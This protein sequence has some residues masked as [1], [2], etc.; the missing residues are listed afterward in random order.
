MVVFVLAMTL[1]V[2]YV[3]RRQLTTSFREDSMPS[4]IRNKLLLWSSLG[5][6]DA[7]AGLVMNCTSHRPLALT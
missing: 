3:S 1:S 5:A 7:A 2:A 6:S 4:G